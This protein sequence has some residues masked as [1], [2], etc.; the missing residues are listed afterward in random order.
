MAP[1]HPPEERVAAR[2]SALG[3]LLH[4][5][6]ALLA[7]SAI[8]AGL[9]G[10]RTRSAPA[11]LAG[12]ARCF[13]RLLAA[14]V[15]RPS[16]GALASATAA[17]VRAGAFAVS[18][19]EEQRS[20]ISLWGRV[21]APILAG[22][23]SASDAR[24]VEDALGRMEAMVSDASAAWEPRRIDVVVVGASA[25]GL[26]ALMEL[27][28]PFDAALPATL[29]VALHLSEH[30]HGLVPTLL[31]R[32]TGL[33]VAWAVDGAALH[34]GHA[35]VAP[36]GGHLVA[37]ADGLH[38]VAGP[39]VHY[40]RPS[41]DALFESAAKTFGAHVA[42]V[43]LSGTGSDGADGTRVVKAHGGLTFVQAPSAAEFRGMPDA[44]IGTGDVRHVMR[45]DR[46]GEE[47]KATIARGRHEP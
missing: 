39:P 26:G 35:F 40:V 4:A 11:R 1:R 18:T 29:L 13:V 38:V 8:A 47:L 34:L 32:H 31:S 19:Q 37:R 2:G 25:G 27:L 15:E 28:G 20:I 9:G 43:I 30:S 6:E 16:R 17:Q 45:A 10:L 12:E 44:A 3:A 21:V 5:Q 36:P 14:Y 42:S 22:S 23:G 7:A 46:I 33:D 24:T 41:A